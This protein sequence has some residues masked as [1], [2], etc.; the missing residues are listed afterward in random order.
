MSLERSLQKQSGFIGFLNAL[1]VT[2]YCFEQFSCFSL[3]YCCRICHF[4]FL[5]QSVGIYEIFFTFQHHSQSC[6]S[7]PFLYMAVLNKISS[8]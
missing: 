6:G 2:A 3:L 7:V 4:A 8:P 1:G 5:C